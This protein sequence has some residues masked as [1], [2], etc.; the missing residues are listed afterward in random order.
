[1][2]EWKEFVWSISEWNMRG[3]WGRNNWRTQTRIVM[4]CG[5]VCASISCTS[6]TLK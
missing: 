4:S 6:K 1:M 5:D 3:S 2:L